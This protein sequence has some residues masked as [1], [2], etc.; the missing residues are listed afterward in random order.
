MLAVVFL[1]WLALGVPPPFP[2]VGTLNAHSD[3]AHHTPSGGSIG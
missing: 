1:R 2:F 3:F